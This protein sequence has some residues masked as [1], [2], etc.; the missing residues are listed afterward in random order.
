MIGIVPPPG[1]VAQPPRHLV[2]VHPR[3]MDVGQHR[4]I[5]VGRER[6]D[7]LDAVVRGFR[8]DAEQ[9]ELP[10]QDLAVDRMVVDDQHARHRA[11]GARREGFARAARLP[12][13]QRRARPARPAA[14]SSP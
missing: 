4:R 9:A 1:S 7:R 8:R 2:A 3:H 6:L 12:R 5:A 11:V 14:T 10:H 13:A